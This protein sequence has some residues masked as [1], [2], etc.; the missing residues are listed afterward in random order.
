[1]HSDRYEVVAFNTA[2][3][4]ANKIHDDAVASSLGFKGGLVPGV[5]V[6]AYLTHLPAENWGRSWLDDGAISGRFERPVYDGDRVEVIAEPLDD[7]AALDLT[8]FDSEGLGCAIGVALA[9]APDA[10]PPI[11]A[12]PIAAVAAEPQ[13]ASPDV[14][15]AFPDGVLGTLEYGFHAES[16][17]TYLDEVRE[18]LP[19]YRQQRLAHPG[20]LLRM[21]NWALSYNVRL[22]PWIHVGSSLQLHGAIEEGQRISVR[23][24]VVDVS[25]R[26]G[27]G[28]V[29][30]DIVY[31]VDDE[32]V[33][34][35]C[36]HTSIYEPRGVRK[37]LG[38][39]SS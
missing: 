23:S 22:G 15:A 2:T 9:S 26:K 32:R 19:L 4:S 10:P 29:E 11:D 20:W 14:F 25:E 18:T 13:P 12:I 21:A 37:V 33:A 39:A 17:E 28:F 30:L 31:V 6:L 36:H 27:H 7:G 3:Q 5:D 16:A 24:R 1:M 34:A 35:T 8:L 38:A